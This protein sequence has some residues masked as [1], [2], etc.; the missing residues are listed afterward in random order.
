MSPKDAVEMTVCALVFGVQVLIIGGALLLLL[1]FAARLAKWAF[2]GD[3][4]F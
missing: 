1:L 4:T 3:A 2:T